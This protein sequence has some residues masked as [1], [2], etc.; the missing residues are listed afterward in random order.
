MK[1]YQ[2]LTIAELPKA[3]ALEIRNTELYEMKV[4]DLTQIEEVLDFEFTNA[5]GHRH[6]LASVRALEELDARQIQKQ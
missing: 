3:K 5:E 4:K 2:L 1:L 6:Y